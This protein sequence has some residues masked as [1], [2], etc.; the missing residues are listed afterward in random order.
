MTNETETDDCDPSWQS[1]LPYVDKELM[2]QLDTL[3]IM[4]DL[5]PVMSYSNPYVP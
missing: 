2:D 1:Q 4:A 5:T 3:E